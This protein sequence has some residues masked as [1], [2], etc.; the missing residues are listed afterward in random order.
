MG[1][2]QKKRTDRIRWKR[3]GEATWKKGTW[4]KIDWGEP[5]NRNKEQD[6]RLQWTHMSRRQQL[7]CL[8][9]ILSPVVHLHKRALAE[10]WVVRDSLVVQTEEQADAEDA[11]HLIDYTKPGMFKASRLPLLEHTCASCFPKCVGDECLLKVLVTYPNT[12]GLEE[13]YRPPF[14]LVILSTGFLV[15]AEQYAS[16]AQHLASHGFVVIMYNKR[17]SAA[18]ARDDVLCA[19]FIHELIDWSCV[20]PSLKLLCDSD[21]VMLVGHS[22][23]GKVSVLAAAQDQRVKAVCLIDPVD[24]T[25]YAPLGPGYPSAVAALADYSGVPRDT[26]VGERKQER[27]LEISFDRGPLAVAVVGGRLGGDCAPKTA[28]YQK[29]YEAS[30]APAWEVAL[31]DAG[32]FQ[33]LDSKTIIQSSVC[34]DGPMGNAAARNIAKGVCAA[35]GDV[36]LRGHFDPS[37]VPNPAERQKKELA[38][39]ERLDFAEKKMRAVLEHDVAGSG[40]R[41]S[42][43]YRLA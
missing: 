18:S 24:N 36:M 29:F 14:P 31:D 30:A 12:T 1:G 27:N 2:T 5:T 15:N 43:R 25:V 40:S 23:G 35:W 19:R 11:P 28:N 34:G 38:L 37:A 7:A 22:R 33:F 10:E 41:M 42:V 21:N 39:Q 8:G 17:E 3:S 13:S 9:T 32:H 4:T 6:R 16:Y 26:I 20:D